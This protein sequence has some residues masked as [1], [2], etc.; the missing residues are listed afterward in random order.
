[1]TTLPELDLAATDHLSRL[2][3]RAVSH[4]LAAGL[5]DYGDVTPSQHQALACLGGHRECTVGELA[6]GLGVSCPAA[7]KLVDR[8]VAK[9]LAARHPSPCDRRQVRLLLTPA[10][11]Q[12][13][14]AVAQARRKLVRQVFS[15]LSRSRQV[16]LLRGMEALL[17][18]LV[19]DPRTALALC[20]HCGPAHH[21]HCLLNRL[22][23]TLAGTNLG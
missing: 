18:S 21:D 14:Q 16:G 9:G 6:A 17:A 1:M 22:H 3:S 10:G 19:T 2:F 23:R 15:Q 13:L 20:L 12:V 7:T 8:L 11:L 4:V 5:Q